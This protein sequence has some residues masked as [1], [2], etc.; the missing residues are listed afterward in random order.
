[1][2]DGNSLPLPDGILIN[3]QGPNQA[4]FEF[5]PGEITLLFSLGTLFLIIYLV[6]KK[7]WLDFRLIIQENKYILISDRTGMFGM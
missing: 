4:S 7:F 6:I 1:M 3:G 2:E 5:E